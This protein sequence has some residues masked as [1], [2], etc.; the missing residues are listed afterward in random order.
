[1]K[2][3]TNEIIKKEEKQPDKTEKK[4]IE[5]PLSTFFKAIY[6]IKRNIFLKKK[7]LK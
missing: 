4:K 7:N 2:D 6:V 3:K 1:M 5:D